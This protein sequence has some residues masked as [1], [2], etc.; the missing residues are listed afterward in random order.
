MTSDGHSLHLYEELMLLA[1]RDDKGTLES[2]ASMYQY[3]LGGAILTELAIEDVIRIRNDKKMFVDH[4][5]SGRIGDPILDECLELVCTAKRRR[6]ASD[7]V[8]R[9]GGLKRLRHR[10]AEG[11]CRKGILENSEGTVLLIFTRKTYPTI[12]PGPESEIVDRLREAIFGHSS[13]VEPGTA[14]VASIA[15]ATGLLPVHFDKKE[16]KTRKRR[17]EE[18]A[19]GDLVGAATAEAVQA[20]QAA[21]IA[22]ISAATVVTTATT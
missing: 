8:A 9:F 20:A 12:D 4:L 6:R 10:V 16:L 17:L 21:A 15:D 19:S 13:Q 22:A 1:L 18:L 7:W 3:A 14:I 2:K 5:S 11:L